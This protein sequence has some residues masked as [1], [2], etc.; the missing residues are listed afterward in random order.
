MKRAI[1]IQAKRRQRASVKE[2][3]ETVPKKWGRRRL[4]S[5]FEEHAEESKRVRKFNS[6]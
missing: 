6:V 4:F 3:A 2:V 1:G 5:R